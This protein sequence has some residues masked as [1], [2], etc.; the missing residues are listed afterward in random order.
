MKRLRWGV[1]GLGRGRRFVRLLSQME[2]CEVVA[3]CDPDPRKFEG[4]SGPAAF[5]DYEEFLEHGLDAVA[6]IS[7][8]PVH[9]EQSLKALGRGA[10]VLCE[11]PCVY[12]LNEARAVVSAVQSTGLKY[13]LAEDYLWTG[14]F[15]ALRRM[16]REGAF[17][18]VLFAEGDYTHDCRDLMLQDE[19]GFVPYSERDRRPR[20]RR[21]WRATSLPPIQ[22]CSHTLG[23]LLRLMGERVASVFALSVGGKAAPELAPTDIESA[24]LETTAGNII[25]LTC[26]FTVAH[27]MA[28]YY[29]LVGTRG[30]AK[31]LLAGG[32]MGK[33][34]SETA[35]GRCDWQELPPQ[36]LNRP[37][38]RDH[39]EVMVEEFVGS[40]RR[41]TKPP[42]DVYESMDMTVPGIVAHQSALKGGVKM[43]VPDM[44]PGA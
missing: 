8:G 22:Y 2:G 16:A 33:W 32:L 5:T 26:G 43:P 40:I 1:S 18:E 17:G 35:R 11:T 29:N 25:R 4:L 3:V 13:M 20:A 31:L 36:S 12:S 41:D 21:T 14:W 37:D 42:L 19:A 39:L 28:L 6:V 30:S 38:G 7:P 27:P 23:P 34:W 10:H 15:C 24:L 44:R 9:A